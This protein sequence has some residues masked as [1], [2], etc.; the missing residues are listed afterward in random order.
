M[1]SAFRIALIAAVALLLVACEGPIFQ[2]PKKPIDGICAPGATY[3]CPCGEETW[4]SA[5]KSGIQTCKQDYS[6]SDC[7]CSDY[8][9]P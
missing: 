2:A 6:V 8:L 4:D 3:V 1:K 7:D 9:G 5:Y